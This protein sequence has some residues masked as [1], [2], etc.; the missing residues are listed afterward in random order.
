MT[1]LSE[2]R[3]ALLDASQ[4]VPD[5]LLDGQHAPAGRR[6]AVYRNNVTVS[7][8][9]AMKTAFPLVRELIGAQNFD[10]LVPMFVRDHPPTS[11]L[12]MFYGAEFPAFLSGFEPLA[13]IGYL[14]DAARLDLAL[15]TSYHAADADPFDPSRLAELDEDTLMSACFSLA[16]ATQVLKSDWPLFDIWRF[17]SEKN[18]PKPRAIA[19][20]ILITRNAFDPAP[21]A[22]PPGAADWLTA[23][24]AGQCLADAH[25]AGLKSHPDFDIGASLTIALTSA[26]FTDLTL[27][28][29][30]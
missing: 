1:T 23:L 18:A 29:I 16:P 9:E 7:L 17:N 21:H 11:P 27:K 8:I 3:A 24:S 4:P 22:I 2:F 12:M 15:R 14:P 6:Y 10:T 30:K 13:H 25:D 5:G 26:A 19:Q 20:D 28:D